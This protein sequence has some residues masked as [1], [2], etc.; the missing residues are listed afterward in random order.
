MSDDCDGATMYSLSVQ[1]ARKS[2]I[3][4]RDF[5]HGLV[6]LPRAAHGQDRERITAAES[7]T[8]GRS[9]PAWRQSVVGELSPGS[10]GWFI[11]VPATVVTCPE[12]F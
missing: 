12:L 11:S 1:T 6:E 9:E 10:V 5:W 4:M 7:S 8:A 3:A 2:A